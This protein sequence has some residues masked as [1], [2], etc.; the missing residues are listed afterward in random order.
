M[1]ARDLNAVREDLG[2]M[3]RSLVAGGIID[4]TGI[5]TRRKP[6][7]PAGAT[8]KFARIVHTLQRA[9]DENNITVRNW[10]EVELLQYAVQVWSATHGTYYENELVKFTYDGTTLIYR[11][12]IEHVASAALAPVVDGNVVSSHWEESTQTKAWVFGYSGD[13]IETIPWL[14]PDDIVE[15]V[16]YDDDRFEDR[17]WWILETVVRVEEIEEVGSGEPVV[18][19]SL[20]WNA[21]ENRA[22]SV[23]V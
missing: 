11:S 18:H 7:R 17:T 6:S 14:Q 15:V 16:A 5:L 12:K 21:D 8:K 10:Y 9:D 2:K 19:S 4:S 23:Y 1:S 22:I 3:L 13:L 20:A